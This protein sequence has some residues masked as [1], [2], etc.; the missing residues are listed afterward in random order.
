MGQR[1]G[2]AAT[3]V[4]SA[5]HETEMRPPNLPLTGSVHGRDQKEDGHGEI[6][7]STVGVRVT[8]EYKYTSRG[9]IPFNYM[10]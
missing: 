8:L 7:M 9:Y 4:R 2:A 10:G 3:G 1:S 5:A 6:R